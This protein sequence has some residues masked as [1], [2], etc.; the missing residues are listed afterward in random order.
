MGKGLGKSRERVKKKGD[1][2]TGVRQ[3]LINI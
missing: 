1:P 3:E 2:D